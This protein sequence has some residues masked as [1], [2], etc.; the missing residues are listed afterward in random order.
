MRSLHL[1]ASSVAVIGLAAALPPAVSGQ[2]V[3]QT[4]ADDRG[5]IGISFEVVEDDWGRAAAI[6]VIDVVPGSPAARAG[7]R[8]G[9]NILAINELDQAHELAELTRRLRLSP[10]DVAVAEV[11]RDGELR[12]LRMVAGTVPADV[13]VGRS[14]TVEIQP[15]RIQTWVRSIDSLR[16]V[17]QR[18][19]GG[20]DIRVLARNSDWGTGGVT[21]V[22]DGGV[23][24][25]RAA[26]A[27]FEFHLF[28]GEKYDS[29]NRE[30]SELNGVMRDLQL[31]LLEREEQLLRADRSRGVLHLTEDDE[32]RRLSTM[33]QQLGARTSS[34]RA[35]MAESARETA[36]EN[37]FRLSR[38]E[39]GSTGQV[40]PATPPSPEF[41]PLTPY[42]VGRNRLAGAEVVDVKPELASYFGVRGGVLIVDVT[43]G[44]PADQAGIVPG[45]VVTS[46]DGRTV[47]SVEALREE[48]AQARRE[49]KL[50][51]VRRGNVL[52]VT[53][54]R[55]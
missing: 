53:L 48:I 25:A 9:D 43:P 17:I 1:I 45:D 51:L 28:Q 39:V 21:V 19:N 4:A 35:A 11:E 14:V 23:A 42:L 49:V 7:V 41:R 50:E 38:G 8:V 20:Q 2:R 31:R 54:P 3:T 27:P 55:R 37:Y 6:R 10:G 47:R 22:S 5:W 30:M 15:E 24:T 40:V 26:V 29:L 46:I 16:V 33:L 13:V 44:T 52:E 12:S 18:R 36:G 34:I 32:F